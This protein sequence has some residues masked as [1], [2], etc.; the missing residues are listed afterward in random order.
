MS[1]Q[2][3]VFTVDKIIRR[4]LEE[5]FRNNNLL[6]VFIQTPE[7]S[8]HI[9]L[10]DF[11]LV[12]LDY[13]FVSTFNQH[14]EWASFIEH[15]R[16]SNKKIIYL[17][18][19]FNPINIS[20]LSNSIKVF[21]REIQQFDKLFDYIV[22]YSKSTEK[23]QLSSDETDN[24]VSYQAFPGAKILLADDS[25]Q[26]RKYVS[27]LL[28]NNK[29]EVE[30][31][32][33]GQLLLD[34]LEKDNTCNIILLDNEMP[35]LD[36]ISTLKKLKT[37]ER[38]KQIPVLFLSA[39]SEKELIVRSLQFGADDYIT[40]PFHVDEFFA[41]LNVHLNINM[42]NRQII[43]QRDDLANTLQEL[44][45]TNQLLIKVFGVI[46]HDLRGPIG[47]FTS[48]LDLVIEQSRDISIEHSLKIFK[49]I[50]DSSHNIY[51]LLENLLYWSQCQRN[52]MKL[53]FVNC[54]INNMI[55]DTTKLLNATAQNK[56]IEIKFNPQLDVEVYCDPFA[57]T[58]VLRNL[59]SNALKFTQK[60]GTV[61]IEVTQKDTEVVVL[62]AD[63]GIGIAPENLPK[64]FNRY[65]HF[66]TWGTANEKGSGLGLNLCHEFVE[67]HG[68][69]IWVESEMGKGTS[70]FF[71]LPLAK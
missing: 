44:N 47:N 36:G 29:Y 63:N 22:E 27:Q 71:T 46:A 50:K 37:S 65:E 56:E 1:K 14:T 34:Y 18:D 67:K 69:K 5:N 4:V 61:S 68:E 28:R 70:F 11:M 62:I 24:L 45:R 6:A 43:S 2:L 57:I 19:T 10:H 17:E 31:F 39:L 40:K 54:F 59:I 20:E 48:L 8:S 16:N 55:T 21:K 32:E 26:I 7:E 13:K 9:Q 33:N 53:N 25:N 49:L 60:K 42:M 64:L 12:M 23:E 58:T 30:T 38:F 52:E 51:A 35:V 41:R 15:L 3:I 66:T